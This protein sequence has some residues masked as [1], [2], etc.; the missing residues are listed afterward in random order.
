MRAASGEN[1][2]ISLNQKDKHTE[3][4]YKMKQLEGYR[5]RLLLI[6]FL[7][8]ILNLLVS[9]TNLAQISTADVVARI[10]EFL[11]NEVAEGRFCGSVLVAHKGEVLISKGYG[12]ANIEHGVPNTPDTK[13]RTASIT[14]QFTA[15]AIM[16]LQERGLLSMIPLVCICLIALLPGK[17]SQST[18]C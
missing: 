8:V 10:D 11:T 16:M 9:S 15:M 5:K 7:A 18:I 6:G 2:I 3:R 13:F 12:M 1:K 4:R 14:K 17:P